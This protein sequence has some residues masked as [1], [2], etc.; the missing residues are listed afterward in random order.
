[1]TMS[2]PSAT[3]SERS[4][5]ACES[6]GQTFAGR[7]L[8]ARPNALRKPRSAFFSASF[9]LG[10]CISSM[11]PPI[12]PKRMASERAHTSRVSSGKWTP[13]ASKPAPPILASSYVIWQSGK[14]CVR[15]STLRASSSPASKCRHGC[16]GVERKV[17]GRV[18]GHS[19]C[20]CGPA[21]LP[22]GRCHLLAALPPST[23]SRS[24]STSSA[25]TSAFFSQDFSRKI[26]ITARGVRG[27]SA[28]A[29]VRG[30]GS[31]HP[32]A[33]PIRGADGDTE[34]RLTFAM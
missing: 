22:R 10:R 31:T 19:V 27:L 26:S 15:R 4:G 25:T 30:D 5:E 9:H 28:P 2:T 1:M 3:M 18:T 8:T 20:T 14:S 7:T 17:Q 16:K 23:A 11:G 32:D 6:I 34:S 33:T 29:G 12:D 13:C 24:S 21:A